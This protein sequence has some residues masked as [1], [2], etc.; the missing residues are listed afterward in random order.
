MILTEETR[1][2]DAYVYA[3][4]V[5]RSRWPEAEP[6]ILKD[7]ECSILYATDVLKDAWP[8]AEPLFLASPELS[9]IYA[10]SIIKG[11]WPK[12]EPT[13]LKDIHAAYK[14]ARYVLDNN[15]PEAEEALLNSEYAYKYLTY[16]AKSPPKKLKGVPAGTICDA[17]NL[18]RLACNRQNYITVGEPI[19]KKDPFYAY[20]YARDIIKGR[21]PEA[22][23]TIKK[24]PDTWKQ[25]KRDM[26]ILRLASHYLDK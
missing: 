10:R 22:E 2:Y 4:D 5:I 6:T 21:W 17:E 24:D 19:I 11:R 3:K 8:E 25:Y 9:L 1:P 12:A 14:Y 16:V 23:K 15:W 7:P 18:Y 26:K 13:I 20:L